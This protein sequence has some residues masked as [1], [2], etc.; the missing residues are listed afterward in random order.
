MTP[1]VFFR[2]GT[3]ILLYVNIIA[4]RV[5]YPASQLLRGQSLV[6]IGL[7]ALLFCLAWSLSP[8][9][10]SHLTSTSLSSILR[11]LHLSTYSPSSCSPYSLY[12]PLHSPFSCTLQQPLCWLVWHLL[13]RWGKGGKTFIQTLTFSPLSLSGVTDA[14]TANFTDSDFQTKN[15]IQDHPWLHMLYVTDLCFEFIWAGFLYPVIFTW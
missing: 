7:A 6:L 11:L 15:K 8:L 14:F 12:P 5:L 13:F 4:S 9:A 1:V 2:Q 10:T 3:L